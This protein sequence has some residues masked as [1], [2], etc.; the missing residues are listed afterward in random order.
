M[1]L[2]VNSGYEN[3]Q[4]RVSSGV[5]VIARAA[6]I[7]RTLRQHPNGLT[8]SQLACEVNLARSTVHRIVGALMEERL[9]ESVP[10]NGVL[11]LGTGLL[12]LAAAVNS[13]LRREL[14]PYLERL[15]GKVTETVDL[16]CF[17]D[18][19][20][21]FIDQIAAPHRLQ[22]VSAVG[23]SFPLHCTANGK[24]FLAALSLDDCKQVLPQKLSALTPN[25]ITTRK[26]LFEEIAQ[27][28][29]GDMAYDREEHT[30]GICAVGAAT[31]TALGDL[32]ALSIP[33]PSQRF[34]AK[35]EKLR[36]ALRGVM[37]QIIEHFGEQATKGN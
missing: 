36:E 15:H 19:Q 20:V 16:A 2:N 10:P 23:V 22:A 6:K 1:G 37:A 18:N 4:Q 8:S 3:G 27:I 7:M 11:Q 34:R 24:A 30:L 17:A 13:D 28:Q 35:E 14:R 26:R 32:I 9:V 12:P 21:R 29:S 33:V 25:T 31:R 5:Q